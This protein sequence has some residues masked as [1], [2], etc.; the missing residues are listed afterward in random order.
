ML[1]N[2]GSG[3]WR[4]D[5]LPQTLYNTHSNQPQPMTVTYTVTRL[6]TRGPRKGEL[7]FRDGSSGRSALGTHDTGK[8]SFVSGTDIAIGAGRMGTLNPVQ[9]L[10]RQWVGDKTANAAR[11]AGQAKADRIAAARERLAERMG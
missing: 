9:S 1:A 2:S 5:P 6:K 8:G 3:F 11:F 10:G 4:V 7:W